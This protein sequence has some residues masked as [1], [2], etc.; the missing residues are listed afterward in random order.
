MTYYLK[1]IKVEVGCDSDNGIEFVTANAR[2]IEDL[3]AF[4][5]SCQPIW[6][7]LIRGIIGPFVHLFPGDVFFCFKENWLM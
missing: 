7:F 5:G 2:N 1:K 4:H 3:S 6:L